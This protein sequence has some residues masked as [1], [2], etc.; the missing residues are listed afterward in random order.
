MRQVLSSVLAAAAV[1]LAFSC[2]SEKSSTGP[3]GPP[4]VTSVD[5]AALPAGQVGSLVV[6]AGSNFGATQ[7][8]DAGIV[9]FTNG[10]GLSDTAAVASAADWT[11]SL[12][13]TTVPAGAVT[14]PMIVRTAGGAS[15]TI[16]FTVTQSAAFSPSTVSWSSM[17]RLREGISG[18]ALASA[19]GVTAGLYATQLYVAGGADSTN[20]PTDSVSYATVL[21]SGALAGWVATTVLPAP[22]AVAAAAIATPTNSPVSGSGYL[23]VIG[24]DSTAGGKPVATVYVGTLT[25]PAGVTAWA[26]TTPLPQPIHSAGAAIF[27]GNLYVFGGSGAGNAPVASVYRASIGATGTLGAWQT[28]PSL[29][30]ARSYFGSGINGTFLYVFGGD[31]GTVT[32]NDSSLSATSLGDV[33]YAQIDVRTGD[34][35]TAG[36]TTGANRLKK[37][38]SKL[39]AVVAG[40]AVLVTGGLY[41]GASTGSTE[42]TY[43]TFNA[44]GSVNAFA[45]ATGSNTISSSGGG[46]LFN[47][48]AVGYLDTRGAF[49]VLVAGGDDVTS[50]TKKHTGVWSYEAGPRVRRRSGTGRG[51]NEVMK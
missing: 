48:A 50:P 44:D 49:H 34:L 43:A 8:T 39:T 38:A 51:C 18:G 19:F 2:S 4:V 15:D 6:I 25:A 1:G 9:L 32:P 5:G 12:I 35:T 20:V 29:P 16:Q 37:A 28:E 31:S 45:G 14:G 21:G 17:I 46:N 33:A 27:N 10:V 11:S 22:R 3:S 7:S 24:G 30:F 47:H 40:G 23:Y 26:T 36:W 13:V 42:E 41:N